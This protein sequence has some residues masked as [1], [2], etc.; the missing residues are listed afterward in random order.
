VNSA[1]DSSQ[2]LERNSS[3]S[4]NFHLRK[5]DKKAIVKVIQ[6]KGEVFHSSLNK[7]LPSLQFSGAR[8]ILSAAVA[9]VLQSHQK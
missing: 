7:T 9:Q 3:V 8:S 1:N 4:D 2:E 5:R 6:H